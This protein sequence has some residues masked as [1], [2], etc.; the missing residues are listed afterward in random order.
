LDYFPDQLLS[1]SIRE[2]TVLAESAGFGKTVFEYK[3]GS[4]GMQDY[5][6]LANDF[7]NRRFAS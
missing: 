5:A 2:T 4:L 3:R 7:I 6:R 1:T